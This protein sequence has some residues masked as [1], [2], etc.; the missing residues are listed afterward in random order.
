MNIMIIFKKVLMRRVLI[1]HISQF[2][3]HC[4]AAS[5]IKEALLLRDNTLEVLNING[6]GYF[7]P[8]WEKFVDFIYTFIINYFPFLWGKIYDRKKIV[9]ELNCL[10][11]VVN[12]MAFKKLDIL[13]KSFV[14][15]CIVTTQ[16]FP[17]G[18]VADYKQKFNFKIPLVAVVTD[19]YPHRFW[20][21][22]NV[23]KYIVACKQARE[24][25]I[26][27]EIEK[28]KIEIYGIPVSVKFLNDYSKEA[29]AREF[30]F[31]K[32]LKA[33]LIMGGGLGIG[34]MK[35]IALQLDD[36]EEDF[37]MIVVCGKNR[38]LYKWFCKNKDNFKKPVF[39]FSYVDFVHKLMEFCEII[40][41]KAGGITICEALSKNLAIV[42]IRPIP[43]QEER[44]AN[45]LSKK[46]AIIKAD[47]LEEIKKIIKRLLKNKDDL[48]FLKEQTEKL[49]SKDASLKIADLILKLN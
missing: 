18:I 4:K 21:H 48:N 26:K 6:F 3:G 47:N 13:L 46:K 17:C 1:F 9:K 11:K 8:F 25:L 45:Y 38:R 19:Y 12:R 41:T 22:P 36:L 20:I 43:G 30:E 15:Q 29:V 16:A 5:N 40:I 49:A 33:I 14:P 27:E 32:N 44:N 34:P 24:I 42:V 10:R 37:Q 31:R 23:D 2:G 28:K 39:Y 35:R 7:Y